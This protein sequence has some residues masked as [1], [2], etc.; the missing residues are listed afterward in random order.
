MGFKYNE[1]LSDTGNNLSG[2]ILIEPEV[3]GDDRGFFLESWNKNEW[4]KILNSKNQDKIDFVQDNH[5]RSSKGVLRGLHFQIN[6]VPQGK[7]VRCISGEIYDV[8]VDIRKKSKTFCQWTGVFLSSKNK[9]QLWIPPGFAH[10]FLTLSDFAEVA[11]KTT[12]YWNK[13]CEK[14]LFWDDK[15]ISIKWPIDLVDRNIILSD[16][17]KKAPKINEIEE[18]HLF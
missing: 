13:E 1:L 18:R 14:S 17:D 16:K 4:Y 11:Y 12:D 5:S 8:A 7:L 2:L 9:S 15:N 3:F 6:P 10:G